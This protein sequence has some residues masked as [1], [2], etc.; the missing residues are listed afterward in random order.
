[1]S[2]HFSANQFDSEYRPH[3]LGN[4]EV[5]KAYPN[6]PESRKGCTTVIANDRGHLLPTVP[7]PNTS[8]WG[9]YRNTWQLPDKITREVANQLSSPQRGGSRWKRPVSFFDYFKPLGSQILLS[10]SSQSVPKINHVSL[11][12][13][14]IFVFKELNIQLFRTTDNQVKYAILIHILSPLDYLPGDITKPA[15]QHSTRQLLVREKQQKALG[16]I[17]NFEL[18]QLY[19]EKHNCIDDIA[20]LQEKKNYENQDASHI[21][22][23][24]VP[25]N[26]EALQTSAPFETEI[27]KEEEDKHESRMRIERPVAE[28]PTERNVPEPI[29]PA[30][31]NFLTARK[32]AQ[33]NLEHEPLPDAVMDIAYRKLLSKGQQ[34]PGLALHVNPMATGVA[35]KNYKAGPTQCTKLRVYRP[36][37]CGVVPPILDKNYN[38]PLSSFL[39]KEKLGSM[40]LAIG[41]D[42]RP[43]DP[44]DEPKKPKHID[45]SNGSAAPAVFTLVKPAQGEEG[46]VGRSEGVFNNTLGEIDFFD[47]D[48]VRQYK[49]HR[50]KYDKNKKCD[51]SHSSNVKNKSYGLQ[52]IKMKNNRPRTSSSQ[53]MRQESQLLQKTY[54]LQDIEVRPK[55]SSSQK[56]IKEMNFLPVNSLQERRCKSTSNLS[57]LV[58]VS[59]SCSSKDNETVYQYHQRHH[60]NKKE[61]EPPRLFCPKHEKGHH[62]Y[63]NRRR[64]RSTEPLNVDADTQM[65]QLKQQTEHS[66]SL[67]DFKEMNKTQRMCQQDNNIPYLK[68]LKR[69]EYKTA[70]KAGIPKSNSSGTCTSF[71]SGIDMVSNSSS[72][73]CIKTAL[74]IPKP[75]NPFAKKNYSISTLNPP[76]ACFKGGAGQGGYPEHWRLA[77]VY[78]HAY[79]PIEYRKRPL[80][81]TVFQ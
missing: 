67:A 79:K 15:E 45:G 28:K 34:Y 5:P 13:I 81:Q 30:Y 26:L 52:D 63:H 74:K 22:G 20:L 65:Q 41:W 36:K 10:Y 33:E 64:Y 58:Q 54:G 37:T 42:Y 11:M 2:S 55:T 18:N 49:E 17:P 71:D 23:T 9:E 56:C 3:R 14:Q 50:K 19:T 60:C 25:D 21:L 7:R 47:R 31:C 62:L 59:A 53:K 69:E 51:C 39:T 57:E 75:R 66:K 8:P 4:W 6:R 77:S 80:L 35:C 24:G 16:K 72:I 46:E 38:R 48:I 76:F 70:F 1:M 68:E 32:M 40:D 43:K 61:E 29:V 44:R 73:P 12:Q 78:Q 27:G